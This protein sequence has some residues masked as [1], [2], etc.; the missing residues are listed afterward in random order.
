[1]MDRKFRLIDLD[2]NYQTDITIS[3]DVWDLSKKDIKKALRDE[4]FWAYE[5]MQ[6]I[7]TRP[8]LIIKIK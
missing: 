6:A 7:R 5:D 3:A 4:L 2:F 1:M 8:K